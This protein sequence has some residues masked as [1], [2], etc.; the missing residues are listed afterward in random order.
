MATAKDT[1]KLAGVGNQLPH[2]Y[3]ISDLIYAVRT[4][5]E[6]TKKFKVLSEISIDKLGCVYTPRKFSKKHNF[7]FVVIDAQTEDILFIAEIE[8]AGKSITATTKKIKESL[9]HIKTLKEVFI[10]K[11]DVAGKVIFERKAI[12]NKKLVTTTN[13]SYSDLLGLTLKLKL[14]SLNY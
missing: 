5:F 12:L 3:I 6:K 11:F 9:T 8:R 1:G 4:K 13:S 14:I 7:D 10:I 2:Q